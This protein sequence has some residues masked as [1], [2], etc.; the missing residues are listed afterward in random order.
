M[1]SNGP[2]LAILQASRHRDKNQASGG[3]IRREQQRVK[4]LEG[5]DIDLDENWLRGEGEVAEYSTDRLRGNIRQ[6]GFKGALK[7]SAADLGGRQNPG[8]SICLGF[9]AKNRPPST[10]RQKKLGLK[11]HLSQPRLNT[12]LLVFFWP[13]FRL[14]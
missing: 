5:L 2:I 11:S 1:A 7:R 10:L 9:S 8:A 4:G 13:F 3:E 12:L 6:K 14:F